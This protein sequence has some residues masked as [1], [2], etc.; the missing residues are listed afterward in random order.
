MAL[1]IGEVRRAQRA[2]EQVF[3]L[4]AGARLHVFAVR[5][6][7]TVGCSRVP[8]PPRTR[9]RRSRF[10]AFPRETEGR[11]AMGETFARV[12]WQG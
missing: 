6:A 4:P 5:S 9:V 12:L 1:P 2:R 8:S 10:L 7:W 11:P 3:P